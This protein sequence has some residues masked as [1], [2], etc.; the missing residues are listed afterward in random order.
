M[1]PHRASQSFAEC[2][3]WLE[4]Q[5]LERVLDSRYAYEGSS[6]HTFEVMNNMNGFQ[7]LTSLD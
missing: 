6:G 7:N 2:I 3:L 4:S 5:R 1:V